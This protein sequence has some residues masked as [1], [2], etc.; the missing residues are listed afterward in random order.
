MTNLKDTVA[1]KK[2]SGACAA[3]IG[4]TPGS[5]RP[6]GTGDAI[7]QVTIGP[8]LHKAITLKNMRYNEETEKFI[9]NERARQGHSQRFK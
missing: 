1:R 3:H 7:G 9:L 4:H 2:N 5:T 6:W 8:L